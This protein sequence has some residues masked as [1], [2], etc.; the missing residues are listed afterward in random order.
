MQRN[1]VYTCMQPGTETPDM[2]KFRVSF[3]VR[4]ATF[5]LLRTL[6]ASEKQARKS[7]QK[8]SS[9]M[10]RVRLC[11]CFVLCP[12]YM[13]WV[14]VFLILC[15]SASNLI[16]IWNIFSDVFFLYSASCKRL[17][18]LNF[19]LTFGDTYHSFAHNHSCVVESDA[20]SLFTA[21]IS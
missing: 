12:L 10:R 8:I 4:Q 6:S 3:A 11:P 7:D 13:R 14:G 20:L 17:H 5:T 9:A 19:P 21:L 18:L 16:L 2:I 15:S 1:K